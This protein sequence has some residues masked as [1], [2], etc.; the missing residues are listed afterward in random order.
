MHFVLMAAEHPVSPLL[1]WEGIGGGQYLDKPSGAQCIILCAFALVT[2]IIDEM[3]LLLLLPASKKNIFFGCRSVFQSGQQRL[4]STKP[5]PQTPKF[6]VMGDFLP[7]LALLSPPKRCLVSGSSP[8]SSS[9][10]RRR[11]RR[12]IDSLLIEILIVLIIMKLCRVFV[13][14]VVI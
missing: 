10:R 8:S 2:K 3:L 11:I 13:D 6:W 5:P 12:R 1:L 7:A 14:A 4:V 9:R